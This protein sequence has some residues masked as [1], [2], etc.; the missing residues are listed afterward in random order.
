ML[1][2][3][4]IVPTY[5]RAGYL[6]KSLE[7]FAKQ[8]LDKNSYE[9]IL[10]DNNSSDDTK[11]V[12]DRFSKRFPGNNWVY[13][14]EPKQGLHY[15]RNRGLLLSK[16]E[17]VVFGDDDIEASSQWLE[18]LLLSFDK[19]EKIGIVGG[20]ITPLWDNKPPDWVYDYGT[21]DYN[22][23]FAILNYGSK[24]F[25]L[26]SE[27]V[28]GCNFAIRRKLAIEI[29]GSGP[30]TFPNHMIHY[31]GNGESAMIERAKDRGYKVFYE[32]IASVKHYCPVERCTMDY[33]ILRYKRWAVEFTYRRYNSGLSLKKTALILLRRNID[34]I[35]DIIKSIKTKSKI[36]IYYYMRVQY[37]SIMF[38]WKHFFKLLFSR[39]LREY[40]RR[41]NYLD[42]LIEEDA[43]DV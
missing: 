39:H 9:I 5:N 23:V 35:V 21:D 11:K 3:S 29:N 24:S 6:N 18:S 15:A 25:D 22:G 40:T 7:T 34:I 41:K 30:D 36:N 37:H 20:P 2:V 43:K 16:G 4:L 27:E 10:V 26:Q 31:S 1:R 14:F 38:L 13:Y 19:D 42:E 33:F 32:H 17:I 8:S 12:F 28:F